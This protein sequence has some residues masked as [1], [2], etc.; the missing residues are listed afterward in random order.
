MSITHRIIFGASANLFSRVVTIGFTLVLIPILFRR[1]GHEELG[2]WFMLGQS[3]A[4]IGLLDL[5]FT[6]T[7]TRRIALAKGK[8]GGDP[9]A[10]LSAESQ[11]EI[12]DLITSGK[13]IFRYLT[14]AVFLIAWTS[15]CFFIGQ[16]ELKELDYH[17]VWLA[18]SVMCLGA[19]LGVWA[20]M[21]DCVL[22]G[23]G[24]VG[25]DAILGAV[26][27]ALTLSG[28]IAVVWFGGGLIELAVVQV[29]GALFSRCATF[30]FLRLRQ[31]ALLRTRGHWDGNQVKS[32][33]SPALK[34]WVL[35]T[36]G[37]LVWKTD[38]YFIGYFLG[39]DKIPAYQAAYQIVSNLYI[40][41]AALG[42][43]S[44]VFISQLWQAGDLLQIHSI[45]VRNLRVGL[46]LMVCGVACLLLVGKNVIDI[47]LTPGHFIGEPVLWVFCIT[48]TMQVHNVILSGATRATEHEVFA[49]S[50]L[51]TG[52][53]NVIFTWILIKPF[54]VL[55]VAVG[56]MLAETVCSTW[57]VPY[58]ALKRLAMSSRAYLLKII[59][60]IL[61]VFVI[62]WG[63]GMLTL[64]L[65]PAIIG[66]WLKVIGVT[67]TTGAVLLAALWLL[68]RRPITSYQVKQIS[69]PAIKTSV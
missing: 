2:L 58:R 16:F 65:L 22:A 55:G 14:L 59:L 67:A 25:W 24:Y 29:V 39:A 47:W 66:G 21:W 48:L 31:P 15:G 23:V 19:A 6:P 42:T 11:Q 18:W 68:L 60:P 7:L 53:L 40:L 5:G 50:G 4:F 27:G 28:Q 57:Y 54:G 61:L 8:S 10:V 20:G 34:A 17:T 43:A 64:S 41:A 62:A 3:G 1:M 35:I 9:G 45:V 44:V 69:N 32:M 36:G 33:V 12:A 56:T 37:F 13:V 38:Q 49:I 51:T 30:A 63:L 46:A 26:L 52:L